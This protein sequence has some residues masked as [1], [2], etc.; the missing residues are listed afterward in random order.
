M[1]SFKPWLL[2]HRYPLA[3]VWAGSRAGFK[4][5]GKRKITSPGNRT[6]NPHLSSQQPVTIPNELARIHPC[7]FRAQLAENQCDSV[8]DIC[9][10]HPYTCKA[11]MKILWHVRGT[12]SEH[13][14][15]KQLNSFKQAT[16]IPSVA[17]ASVQP[18]CR[19]Q[20]ATDPTGHPAKH[21][22]QAPHGLLPH[23]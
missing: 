9:S 12:Q 5:L 21:P 8:A 10:L 13:R 18:R 3:E 19:A 23:A 16:R 15:W 1:V 2:C 7:E 17:V 6:P 11:L 22:H 20:G 4:V 14:A